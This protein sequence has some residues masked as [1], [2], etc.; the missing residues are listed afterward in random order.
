[1]PLNLATWRD[2]TTISLTAWFVS[3]GA[4]MRSALSAAVL[5][6]PRASARLMLMLPD[7]AAGTRIAS[8]VMSRLAP[9]EIRLAV[10][11]RRALRRQVAVVI[12]TYGSNIRRRRVA[13]RSIENML[14]KQRR[15]D[16]IRAGDR[17]YQQRT[18]RLARLTKKRSCMRC[19]D[20]IVSP[21]P[22]LCKK[23]RDYASRMSSSI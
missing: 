16:R 6:N 12:D 14:S 13:H 4:S 5:L 8:E 3:M 1:M 10:W 15:E 11:M 9:D 23:C 20:S 7:N 17:E 22:G 21:Y 19:G 18:R 2:D